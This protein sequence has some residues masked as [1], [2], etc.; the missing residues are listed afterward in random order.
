MATVYRT[1]DE[2]FEG[3]PDFPFPP[4]YREA[5]GLRLLPDTSHAGLYLNARRLQPDP[6][7]SWSTPL[8]AYLH[9]L[10]AE[11]G[12]RQRRR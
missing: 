3:L 10:P 11:A 2:R 6:R 7:Y 5:S 8:M 1:P 12:R 4:C 9:Q